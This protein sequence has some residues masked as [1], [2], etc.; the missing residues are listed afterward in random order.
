MIWIFTGLAVALLLAALGFF[1]I[2]LTVSFRC[3]NGTA[4]FR[5]GAGL[6][7]APVEI[8]ISAESE[9]PWTGTVRL[10][11]FKKEWSGK[12]LLAAVRKRW[13]KS[14]KPKRRKGLLNFIF[15]SAT[16]EKWQLYWRIGLMDAA[17]C[18]LLCGTLQ[19]AILSILPLIPAEKDA[20]IS[21]FVEPRFDKWEF[22][23]HLEG[24]FLLRPVQ[25]ILANRKKS[26]DGESYVLSASH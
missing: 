13:K 11:P 24:I 25:S 26:K 14:K 3:E 6:V 5:I 22:A 7:H 23:L 4:S 12:K 1:F 18:A 10:G 15:R 9:K 8:F 20:E 16:L 21:V 17:Q 2:K 19:A